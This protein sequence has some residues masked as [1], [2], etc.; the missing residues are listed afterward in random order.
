MTQ[1]EEPPAPNLYRAEKRIKEY[2]TIHT[3]YPKILV[4]KGQQ[5]NIGDVLY[6]ITRV[7]TE[8][9]IK[10]DFKGIISEVAP[11]Y[12]TENIKIPRFA[13]FN[14][15]LVSIEH[16]VMIN[17]RE[18]W[19][20]K[21]YSFIT[22]AF[23]CDYFRAPYPGAEPYIKVGDKIAKN[24]IVCIAS[25]MKQKEEIPST[26]DGIIAKIYFD[27][28]QTIYRGGKLIGLK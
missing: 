15:P 2:R 3:G 10:S 5:I 23:E 14:V 18:E 20:E 24:Q 9:E 8:K 7:G 16:T 21:H 27:D 19:E 25:I 12:L 17:L 26:L 1:A 6:K 28:G 11:Y 13:Q 22:A 4:K